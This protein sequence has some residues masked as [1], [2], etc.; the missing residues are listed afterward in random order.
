MPSFYFSLQGTVREIFLPHS[1]GKSFGSFTGTL[2][3]IDPARQ[4]RTGLWHWQINFNVQYCYNF[5][6]SS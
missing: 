6:S 3:E 4:R 1:N 2:G 5:P